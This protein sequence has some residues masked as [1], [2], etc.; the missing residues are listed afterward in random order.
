MLFPP[1]QNALNR[2]MMEDVKGGNK[3]SLTDAVL[4]VDIVV[5]ESCYLF[6]GN[7]PGP[8]LKVGARMQ[9]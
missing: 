8:F 6:R 4:A 9:F 7:S 3:E 2:A 1:L 5:K